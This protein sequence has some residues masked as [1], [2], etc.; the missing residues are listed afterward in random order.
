MTDQLGR[1]E[2]A[3]V[4][5]RGMSDDEFKQEL[6]KLV[7]LVHFVHSRH[8]GQLTRTEESDII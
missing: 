1:A 7:D 3:Y 8:F 2:V 6:K 5:R 4:G